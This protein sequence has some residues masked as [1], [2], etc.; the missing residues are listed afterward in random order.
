MKQFDPSTL[1]FDNPSALFRLEDRLKDLLGGRLYYDPYFISRGG[2]R[3]DEE[4]LKPGGRLW[5]WEPTRPSHGIPAKE[6][7][8]LMSQAGLQEVSAEEEKN[9]FKGIFMK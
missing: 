4:V 1:D 3:G 9:S 8:S 7:R 2:F 6:V 5:I